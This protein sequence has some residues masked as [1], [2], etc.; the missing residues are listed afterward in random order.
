MLK[1]KRLMCVMTAALVSVSLFTLLASA[2]SLTTGTVYVSSY[3]NVRSAG[4][5]GAPVIGKLANG[6]KITIKGC[7]NGWDEIAYNNG[8]GWISGPLCLHNGS[9]GGSESDRKPDW[10]TLRIRSRFSGYRI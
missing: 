5:T 6:T 1:F 4:N 9:T 3:L 10:G 2:S 7:V 8:I